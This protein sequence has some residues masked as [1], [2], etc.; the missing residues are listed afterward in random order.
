MSKKLT[1]SLSTLFFAGALSLAAC[2]GDGGNTNNN[3]N[4]TCRSNHQCVNDVCECTTEGKSG[5][6]CTDNDS[7]P[8]E[9][10][11]CS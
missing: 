7:C 10:E 3:S 2:G 1:M 9:C 5:D 4:Q 11:V 8:S 6:S